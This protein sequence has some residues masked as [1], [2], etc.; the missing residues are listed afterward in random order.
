MRYVIF[1][2]I[3]GNYEAFKRFARGMIGFNRDKS[4]CLGD[5][6]GKRGEGEDNK[7]IDLLTRDTVP[8]V[9]YNADIVRG[10]HDDPKRC[11][12]GKINLDN[13][14]F[15]SN[16]PEY[17][18]R[19]EILMFHSS[20]ANPGRYLRTMGDIS[21]EAE[22]MQLHFPDKG[23]F[24][25]G[26]SHQAGV[27]SYNQ[28]TR[29]VKEIGEKKQVKLEDDLKYFV[30]PGTLGQRLV[31]SKN[32]RFMS[33]R[34]IK[35]YNKPHTFATLDTEK[36]EVNFYTL[37]ELRD[38]SL[39][40]GSSWIFEENIMKY[41]LGKFTESWPV[42][43]NLNKDIEILQGINENRIFDAVIN[44]MKKYDPKKNDE[45]RDIEYFDTYSLELANA[46]QRLITDN[47]EENYHFNEPLEIR[48]IYLR[49]R[50]DILKAELK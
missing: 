17:K 19:D 41:L 10:N 37:E 20:L 32:L 44:V 5:I 40:I 1:S 12:R 42:A 27:F 49:R 15:L 29:K 7:V 8:A 36:K 50:E 13:I 47:V 25:F 33:S 35:R 38:M 28:K 31:T 6:M 11:H 23:L 46:F 45:T 48:E 9:F 16:L 34:D 22:Y 14:R 3:Q 43:L 39:R 21:E 18:E 2:D 30:N 26:H 4:I 24:L